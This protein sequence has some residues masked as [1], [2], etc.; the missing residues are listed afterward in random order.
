[1]GLGDQETCAG[2]Q[3]HDAQE[4]HGSEAI[5]APRRRGIAHRTA[6]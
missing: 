4:D 3:Q 6:I 1:V 2:T 5:V